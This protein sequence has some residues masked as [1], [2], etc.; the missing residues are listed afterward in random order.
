MIEITDK[1]SIFSLDKFFKLVGDEPF[2]QPHSFIVD[3]WMQGKRIS[4]EYWWITKDAVI[5]VYGFIRG[6]GDNWPEKVVGICVHPDFRRKG[7]GELMLRWLEKVAWDRGLKS[8]RIHVN[9]KNYPALNLYR[10]LGYMFLGDNTDKGDLVG[11]K[12]L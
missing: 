6:W 9:Y 10:K 8:L 1:V 4:N 7:F 5:L 2:F 11:R 12:R 3:E